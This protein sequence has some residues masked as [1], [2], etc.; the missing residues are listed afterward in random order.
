MILPY[1][2][3]QVLYSPMADFKHLLEYKSIKFPDFVNKQLGQKAI[4]LVLGCC[5]VILSDGAYCFGSMLDALFM[6]GVWF[7]LQ[8]WLYLR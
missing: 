2:T 5:V 3:K 8:F 7:F 4:D 6:Y 1:I